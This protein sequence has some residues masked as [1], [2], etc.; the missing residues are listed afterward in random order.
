MQLPFGNGQILGLSGDAVAIIEV[1][2]RS[3][4][5]NIVVPEIGQVQRAVRLCDTTLSL[6]QVCH[7]VTVG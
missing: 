1:R 5:F 6:V 4:R 7:A 3:T 2:L